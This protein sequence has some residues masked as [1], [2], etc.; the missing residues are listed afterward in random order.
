MDGCG[1]EEGGGLTTRAPQIPA[2]PCSDGGRIGR[3]EDIPVFYGFESAA[4]SSARDVVAVAA[5]EALPA[6]RRLVHERRA[7]VGRALVLRDEVARLLRR[8]QRP[9]TVRGGWRGGRG[10]GHIAQ[11]G[12]G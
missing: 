2:V 6:R 12:H 11:R 9:H 5:L 1:R 4:G 8:A 7:R 10:G 3:D